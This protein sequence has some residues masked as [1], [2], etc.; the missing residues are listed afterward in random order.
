MI[1]HMKLSKIEN[2]EKN[3]EPILMLRQITARSAQREPP[4]TCA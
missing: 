3:K 2:C 1:D 4:R